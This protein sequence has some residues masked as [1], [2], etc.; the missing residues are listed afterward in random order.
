MYQS[1]EELN[2]AWSVGHKLGMRRKV[3]RELIIEKG[4]ELMCVNGVE[5]T[6]IKEIA[7]ATGIL[8]GSFYNYFE[9][10]EEFVKE[11]LENYAIQIFKITENIL[12]NDQLTPIK[13]L[14]LIF[15]QFW[16]N[17]STKCGYGRGCF[18]GNCSQE[19]G[20]TNIN[21][22]QYVNKAFLM[23]KKLYMSCIDEAKEKGEIKSTLNTDQLAEFIINSWQGVLLRAKS[24]K[25][26]EA[27]ESFK[28][29]IFNHLLK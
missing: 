1:I 3:D 17:I 10:K 26:C 4:L 23:H 27:Y 25:N 29:L 21:L 28:E 12:T 7:D 8:K 11:L 22:S 6:G 2:I 16:G 18:L 19:I 15:D 5:N 9:N 24:A 13:R 20:D 14:E